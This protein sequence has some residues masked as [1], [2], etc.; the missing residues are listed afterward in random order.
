MSSELKPCPFCGGKPESGDWYT[1]WEV[2]N[3]DFGSGSGTSSMTSSY[4]YIRHCGVEMRETFN[5]RDDG[6]EL[7]AT[8][9]LTER[10]NTRAPQQ[11]DRERLIRFVEFYNRELFIDANALLDR[12]I[13]E[14]IDE[15]L[16]SEGG[17]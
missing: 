13:Y 12:P 5:R 7:R 10:W 8:N 14:I 9:V 3:A 17:K 2:S 6:G 1:S 4:L 11:S 15:F 16:K